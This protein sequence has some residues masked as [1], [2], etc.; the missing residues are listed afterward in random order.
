MGSEESKPNISVIAE[1]EQPGPFAVRRSPGFEKGFYLNPPEYQT[2]QD[3]ILASYKKYANNPYIGQ[4]ERKGDQFANKFT[5]KTYKECETIAYQFGSGLISLGVQPRDFIGVYSGNCPEWIHMIDVSALYG[6][7]IAALYDTFGLEIL[8]KLI[9]SSKLETILV[10]T[11]N[12]SKLLELMKNDKYS[13]QRVILF[14][15][16]NLST[17]S[18]KDGFQSC[19]INFYTFNDILEIGKNDI[20]PLPKV[21][22]DWLHYIC[23]S[24]GT[25]GMPK[26]VMIS[27]RSQVSNTIN[28]KTQLGITQN[29]RHLS[30]LPLPH[31]FERVAISTILFAGGSIGVFSGSIPR[32]TEDMQ[33]L[34]PTHL[35]AVPRVINRIYD[36]IMNKL[37][38]SSYIKQGI[39]WGCWYWKRFWLKRNEKTPFV[40]RLV[41]DSINKQLGGKVGLFLIGGAALNPWI[42]EF[43]G[44]ATGSQMG[45]GYGLSE[46]GS[47][48]VCNP[49]DLR[50]S[51]PGTV[52]GPMMNCEVRIEPIPDYDDPECGE[53][54]I[55]GQCNC[56]G[57]LNDEQ[58]TKELFIDE[59]NRLGDGAAKGTNWIHTG[60][61][62]KWDDEGY[63]MI[64]DRMRSIFKLSQGEY[65]AAELL[66][67][68]YE[69]AKVINQIFIYGDA[70][71]TYLVAIVV[72]KISEVAV[73]LKKDRISNEEYENACKSKDFCDYVKEQL[74]KIAVEHNLPGYE[75]I[76]AVACD[77]TEWTIA[78]NMLTP[79]FKLRRKNLAAKY[80]KIIEDLY[81]SA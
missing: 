57:Y 61:V 78:N 21:E 37:H 51:K 11:K 79:T 42:H 10:S 68:T 40:D 49:L 74:E 41:F 73:F 34:Q 12:A 70:M 36:N 52:G 29:S 72:P 66:T 46:V 7:V 1:G 28:C 9:S 19:D 33:I 55:C 75:R 54:L 25:T 38:S 65:V 14:S 5:F 60:D 47:G 58:A 48:V 62:G 56:S 16:P 77:S 59:K 45:V 17:D 30:Y 32:L 63:L 53:I 15:D 26:G 13:V 23:F 27:H 69:M 81:E 80:E 39:F 3:I 22:P 18:L 71:R 20:K 6:H 50:Y 24:S 67:Q 44:F 76:R 8:G 4:R 64:V 35:T 43:I 2:I 31:V